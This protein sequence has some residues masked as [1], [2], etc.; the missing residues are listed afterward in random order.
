[1]IQTAVRALT[2]NIYNV[3]DNMVYDFITTPPVSKYFTDIVHSMKEQCVHLDS[4]VHTAEKMSTSQRRKTLLLETDKV[5]DDLYYFKDI[6][7]VDDSRLSKMIYQNL[8]HLLILP[9][10]FSLLQLRQSDGSTLSA[11]TSIYVVSRVLQVV[12]GKD[13][14]KSVAR[15]VLHPYMSLSM[16]DAGEGDTD[17]SFFNNLGDMEKVIC[18]D[19]WPAKEGIINGNTLHGHLPLCQL[20]NSPIDDNLCP[21]RFV[22]LNVSFIFVLLIEVFCI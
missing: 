6:L 12:G 7:C 9:I 8:L 19:S 3:S 2:L 1:M 21:E 20:I 14:T 17:I 22:D 15:V 4:L 18:S 5:V 13:F 16:K 10:L 11:I